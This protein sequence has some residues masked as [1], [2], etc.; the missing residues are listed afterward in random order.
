MSL[1]LSR[2]E[3]PFSSR[4]IDTMGLEV[5]ECLTRYSMSTIAMASLD[6]V[7]LDLENRSTTDRNIFSEENIRLIDTQMDS[8]RSFLDTTDTIDGYLGII[9]EE[10]EEIE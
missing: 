1:D 3:H 4:G 7:S 9:P 10:C 6:T 5:E 2:E 8:F